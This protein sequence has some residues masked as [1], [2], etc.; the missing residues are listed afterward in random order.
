MIKQ[1]K[2]LQ[3]RYDI[4]HIYDRYYIRTHVYMFLFSVKKRV[5]ELLRVWPWRWPR[6][7]S[8][9]MIFIGPVFHYT[10]KTYLRRVWHCGYEWVEKKCVGLQRTWVRKRTVQA[11]LFKVLKWS[12][13]PVF[14][15][16]FLQMWSFSPCIGF[17]SGMRRT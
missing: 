5:F 14:N 12:I 7:G 16:S 11:Y 13:S 17:L 2:P 15:N 10:I 3:T 6:G 4:T 9:Y 8:P 1:S